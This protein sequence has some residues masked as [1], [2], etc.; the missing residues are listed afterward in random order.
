LL[1]W[2]A[3]IVAAKSCLICRVVIDAREF[4]I[5]CFFTLGVRST[6]VC[7]CIK[8]SWGTAWI[9]TAYIVS[10][11]IF[12]VRRAKSRVCLALIDRTVINSLR[13]GG[14]LMAEPGRLVKGKTVLTKN[15]VEFAHK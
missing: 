1:D 14:R 13:T 3:A 12:K 5:F 10:G 7:R 6:L 2:E 4:L 9:R 11:V 15:R 8:Y